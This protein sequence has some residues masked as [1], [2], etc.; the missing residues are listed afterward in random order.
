MKRLGIVG[1]LLVVLVAVGV[2]VGLASPPARLVADGPH[3]IVPPRGKAH[4]GGGGSPNMVWHNGPILTSTTVSSIFW[5]TSWASSP[6]DK[7]SGL[8]GF[9]QG[10]A[11]S[12]YTKTNDEYTGTNG[13]V[14]AGAVAFSSHAVDTTAAPG[15][16]P[17]TGAVLAEVAKETGNSPVAYG[18]YPVYSD[19][20][21]GHAG[22]CAWHSSGTI[23]GTPVEFAFFFKLDGDPGCDP[24]DTSGLHSQGLAALANVSGHELSETL[25]DP[26]NG[27]WYDTSGA[28][29][30]DKCAWT[31]NVPSVTFTGGTQW[32]IQ[33]NWSNAAYTAGTGYPN[34]AGQQ[35]CLDGH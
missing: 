23:N 33:G 16:A 4:G 5:G 27:G 1:V 22:Y 19:Q 18:Y 13:Q 28:E 14:G 21:R 15:K 30:A 6:G 11:N 20:P 12:N 2:S 25:T 32:K 31:F 26:S 7:I 3:G 8:D 29:N 24:Q 35:G 17:S 10:F 9:Y 34:S